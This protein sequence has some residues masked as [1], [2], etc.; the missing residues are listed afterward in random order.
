M[1]GAALRRIAWA[2]NR[3]AP[4][5]PGATCLVRAIATQRLLNRYGHDAQ[6]HIGVTKSEEQGFE[7][8]AWVECNGDILVGRTEVPYTPLLSR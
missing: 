3:T 8:H 5:V 2:I 7:A 4:F 1:W 6:L